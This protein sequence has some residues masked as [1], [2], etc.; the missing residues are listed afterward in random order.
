MIPNRQL[1]TILFLFLLSSI[2]IITA[3]HRNEYG[4]MSDLVDKWEEVKP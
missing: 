2:F 1:M 3:C 4:D